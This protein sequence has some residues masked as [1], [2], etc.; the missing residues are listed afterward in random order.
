MIT[1][2]K[3]QMSDLH[4]IK[5]LTDRMLVGTKLGVATSDKILRLVNNSSANF[6]LAFNDNE[7]IGF[8]LGVAHET[9][10]NNVMR[11]TDVGI[12]VL[13]EYRKED[14][15]K[16]L[17]SRFEEWAVSRNVDQIWLGQTT[18]DRIDITKRF[19]E[20][21]GYTIVGVNCVKEL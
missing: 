11:A 14:V 2:R 3:A 12:Y 19:Y 16:T 15:A 18:G 10:F 7:C 8:M 21:Q 9:L 1:Y 20:R 13:P 5:A 6:D 4:K 17:M